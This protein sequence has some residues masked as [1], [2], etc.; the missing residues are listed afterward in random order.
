ME[1]ALAVAKQCGIFREGK[2][3][4]LTDNEIREMS[5]DEVKKVLSK[6]MVVSRCSPNTK[7]RL[8]TLAQEMGRSVA[9]TGDG[10]NDSPALKKSDVGFGMNS[11]SD[12]AK[13]ASDIILTDNNFAS[14]VKSVE[15][16]RTFMHNIMMFLEF[17]L[18]I[19]ISLLVLSI[20]FPIMMAIPVLTSVQIL[21]INVIMDTLNS[22]SFGGE[23]PKEEYMR[24][25]PIRKGAGLFIRG[26]KQRIALSTVSF[27]VF[28]AI[29]IFSPIK[30]S[31]A[32]N[33]KLTQLDLL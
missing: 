4:A 19:N 27:L 28:Y 26:S 8:V 22:L 1:T 10:V 31:L 16:G 12:V 21:L 5:D 32:Q 9:M 13:A 7:L 2:D 18:H 25:A 15:L 29:L 6:L 23:P 33:S 30:T 14:V 20:F 17:Q 11:G 24:E 3:V